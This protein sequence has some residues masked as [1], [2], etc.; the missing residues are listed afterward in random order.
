MPEVL[1]RI[2]AV[3][4]W[5]LLSKSAPTQKLAEKPTRFH[6]ENM[7]TKSYLV[8]PETSSENRRYIPMGYIQ[9]ETLTSNAM[10]I[11][12]DGTLYHF[13]VLESEMHMTWMR[14]V[15]G[16]LKSDYRYSKDIVYN[17]FP[18][19]EDVTDA[20]KREVEE[21]AQAVLDVRKAFPN[22]TL[23]DL[24]DPNT[25]PPGLLKAHHMLDRVVD[26]CYGIKKVFS[27]EPARLE[28]LFEL[29]KKLTV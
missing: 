24:Y 8:I 22:A 4:Q 12:P 23:A 6:V 15:A 7:P 9:P 27:S 21:K 11:M 29:Y 20:Q 25:M 10:K 2:D 3:R 5:R 18:W 19:P 17:N 26:A 1:R 16:R 14:A 28:F 13:G